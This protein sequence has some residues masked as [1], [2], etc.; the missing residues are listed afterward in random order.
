[1]LRRQSLISVL[2][3]L[4]L[5]VLLVNI[6]AIVVFVRGAAHE[7][8]VASL[9]QSKYLFYNESIGSI[10]FRVSLLEKIL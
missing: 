2:L 5:L 4:V 6:Y 1:M 8:D 3:A 10:R 7:K 9:A